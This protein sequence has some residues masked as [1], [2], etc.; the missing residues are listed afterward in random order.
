MFRCVSSDGV[1]AAPDGMINGADYFTL[2]AVM[3][4]NPPSLGGR[5]TARNEK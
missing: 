1:A 3:V 5:C 2:A 4:L